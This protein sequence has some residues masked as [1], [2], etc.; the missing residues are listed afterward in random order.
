[1]AA[2]A[3]IWD[4]NVPPNIECQSSSMQVVNPEPQIPDMRANKTAFDEIDKLA[5]SLQNEEDV[6]LQKQKENKA[7]KFSKS[8]INY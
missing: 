7:K 5:A 2:F 1:M 4:W 3:L 8:L 6:V